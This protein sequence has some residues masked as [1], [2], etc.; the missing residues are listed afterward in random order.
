[1]Y[2]Q[3]IRALA[4]TD[5]MPAALR[6]C[7]HEYGYAIVQA[8]L[9]A[10]VTEPRRIHQLVR[11]IW[12]GAR[13]PAQRR[14]PLGTLD[15][16]LVQARAEINAAGLMRVL[17]HDHYAILPLC[18]CAPMIDASVAE[19]SGFNIRCTKR[20]K[21]RRRLEAAL[22]AGAAYLRPELLDERRALRRTA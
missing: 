9:D 5:N 7:V 15:W 10:K 12:A 18:P 20:E 22:K 21:H 3:S 16:I 6:E 2:E 17:A 13:Q 14:E 19:V 1:M 8:C 4:V 11:E